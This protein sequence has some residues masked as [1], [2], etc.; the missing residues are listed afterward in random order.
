MPLQ[1]VDVMRLLVQEP[2]LELPDQPPALV[3]VG[4]AAL[5]LVEL[6]E[7]PIGVAA[8][9]DVA[10]I[11]GLELEE[12]E[13]GL[14]DVAAVEVGGDLEIAAADV[15]VEHAELQRLDLGSNPDLAPLVGQPDSKA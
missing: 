3:S 4:D 11:D 12:G 14:D 15:R 6:V 8:V 10:P 13:V 7:H 5:L 2:L 9:V 1:G